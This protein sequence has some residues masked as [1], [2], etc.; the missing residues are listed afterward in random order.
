MWDW[1]FK[2]TVNIKT[3]VIHL[4]HLILDSESVRNRSKFN[5]G[6]TFFKSKEQT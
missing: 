3:Y 6:T 5:V 2:I 1:A 4:F